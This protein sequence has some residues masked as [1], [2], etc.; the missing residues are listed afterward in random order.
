M[1][2]HELEL[3]ALAMAAARAGDEQAARAALDRLREFD[4]GAAAL[5][6]ATAELGLGNREAAIDALVEADNLRTIWIPAIQADPYLRDLL[7]APR[8]RRILADLLVPV[9]DDA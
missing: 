8:V 9:E 5:A 6:I 3:G 7:D 2:G 1:P 4:H